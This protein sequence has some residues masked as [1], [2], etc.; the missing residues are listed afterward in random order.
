MPFLCMALTRVQIEIGAAS[1]AKALAIIGTKVATGI[2]KDQQITQ[3]GRQVQLSCSGTDVG[4]FGIIH[5][6]A[7]GWMPEHIEHRALRREL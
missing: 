1:G 2:C 7:F 4:D 6:V 3:L 5:V